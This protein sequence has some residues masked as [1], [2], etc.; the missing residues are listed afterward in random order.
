MTHARIRTAMNAIRRNIR[1]YVGVLLILMA[2]PTLTACQPSPPKPMVVGITGYNFTREGVQEYYVDGHRGSNLPPYGGGG[3][4]SCCIALPRQWSSE[5]TVQLDWTIGHYTEPWEKRKHMSVEEE[6]ACCWTQRSLSK[7]VPVQRYGSEG[8]GV[9]VF[10]LPDDE[11][12]IYVTDYD[13]GH[14]KHPSGMAYPKK[15]AGFE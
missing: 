8:G 1:V 14:E 5:Q 7:S 12:R 3:S 10:F 9:Q 2:G 6:S 13:L 4:L 15:P 11:V